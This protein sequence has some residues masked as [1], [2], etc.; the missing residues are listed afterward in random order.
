MI[1][2]MAREQLQLDDSGKLLDFFLVELIPYFEGLDDAVSERVWTALL[3]TLK[4]SI[5]FKST[6][7]KPFEKRKY[8]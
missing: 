7:G 1:L 5:Q 4:W 8:F 2:E 3:E 6:A